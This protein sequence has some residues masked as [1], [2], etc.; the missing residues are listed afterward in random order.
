MTIAI[1]DCCEKV[2]DREKEGRYCHDCGEP[3]Q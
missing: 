3:A 1:E 2:K